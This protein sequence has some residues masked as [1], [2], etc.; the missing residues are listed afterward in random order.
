MLTNELLE[1][2]PA[3]TSIWPFVLIQ[4]FSGNGSN[5][6]LLSPSDIQA[7]LGGRTPAGSVATIP[8]VAEEPTLFAGSLNAA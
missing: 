7:P 5:A 3:S 4:A 6:P 8:F 2:V 1:L